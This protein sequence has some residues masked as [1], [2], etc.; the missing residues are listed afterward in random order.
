MKVLQYYKCS[1]A[2]FEKKKVKEDAKKAEDTEKFLLAHRNADPSSAQGREKQDRMD[3]LMAYKQKLVMMAGKFTFPPPMPLDATLDEKLAAAAATSD[4]VIEIP[5]LSLIKVDNVRF[6]YNAAKGLPFIF[7]TPIS[8]DIT[9]RT[10]I[11]VMGPNGAGKSTFLKLCTDKLKPDSGTVTRHDR[12]TFAYFSQHH[13][14]ELNFQQT[15]MEFM[16]R[17]F[18]SVTNTGFLRNHLSKVG[19]VGTK[20]DTRLIDLSGGQRSCVMFAKLTYICPHMLIMDEPTNFLDLIS[21]DSLIAAT[22][23][24]KGALMLVSHNRF[25]LNKCA[26]AFLS[27]VPGQFNIYPDLAKCERATYS[28]IQDLEDGNSIDASNLIKKPTDAASVGFSKTGGS[29]DKAEVAPANT[30]VSTSASG[31]KVISIKS[32][33]VKLTK[34]TTVTKPVAPQPVPAA[35]SKAAPAGNKKK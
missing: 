13:T 20:A 32:S 30:S 16:I 12:A 8:I 31:A 6:S 29:S 33:G 4:V 9:T 7:D 34:P 2:E 23:K 25:F 5:E 21:V 24:Y 27:I 19:I 3:W 10:R 14:M 15:P 11:G 35:N 17:E 22:R 26:Q 18:P 28:F 1:F